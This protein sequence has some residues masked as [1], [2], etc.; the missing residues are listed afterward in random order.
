M[1]NDLCTRAA[2]C[3]VQMKAGMNLR[4]GTK[5]QQQT[6]DQDSSPEAWPYLWMA[7]TPGNQPTSLQGEGAAKRKARVSPTSKFPLDKSFHQTN[8]N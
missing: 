6:C 5:G 7:T 4:V 8:P 2:S 1:E 3:S